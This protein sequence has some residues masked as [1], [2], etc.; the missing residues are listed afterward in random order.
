MFSDLKQRK[1]R[2]EISVSGEGGRHKISLPTFRP[3]KL[4]Q[5]DLLYLSQLLVSSD[6]QLLSKPELIAHPRSLMGLSGVRNKTE[7]P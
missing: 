7:L 4:T 1:E 2:F 3:P 5:G 6:T